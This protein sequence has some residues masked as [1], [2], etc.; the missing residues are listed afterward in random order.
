MP[1]LAEYS[2]QG[3][4]IIFLNAGESPD[5]IRNYLESEK[6]EIPVMLD[7][8]GIRNGLRVVGLP[9][10]FVI[11]ADGQ[12]LERRMGPLDRGSLEVLLSQVEPKG[13]R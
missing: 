6:L 2:K 5:Q 10:T 12:I 9:S 8:S 13:P 1:L 3:A 4:T 11:G 7:L